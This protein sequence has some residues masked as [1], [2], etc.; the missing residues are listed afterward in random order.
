MEND[1]GKTNVSIKDEALLFSQKRYIESKGGIIIL[2]KIMCS[3]KKWHNSFG[4][5]NISIQNVA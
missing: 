3:L 1:F 5:C 2:A 4:K